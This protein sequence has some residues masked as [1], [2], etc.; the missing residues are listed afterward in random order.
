MN[1]GEWSPDEAELLRGLFLDEAKG[2]LRAIAV[3]QQT[4]ARAPQDPTEAISTLFRH[5]HTLKGS[6]GSVGYSTIARAAHELE[7]LCAEIRSFALAPTAG[8]LDRIDEGVAEL[9]AL[10]QG[11]HASPAPPPTTPAVADA[12]EGDQRRASDRRGAPDR[13]RSS[14]DGWLRIKSERLDSLVDRVGDLVILRTRIERRLQE[15]E[16]GLRDLR[17]TRTRLRSVLGKLGDALPAPAPTTTNP[18]VIL[19]QVAEVEL[20]LADMVAHLE[21]AS[22]ALGGEGDSLRRTS[23]QLDTE[24]RQ[25]RLVPLDTLFQRVAA[26]LRELEKTQVAADLVTNGGELEVDKSVAEHLAEPLLHLVRNALG[27]GIETP[28]VRAA[29]GKPVRGRIAITARHEG[30]FVFLKFEDDGRGIDP[31]AVKRTLTAAGRHEGTGLSEVLLRD[32]LFEPGFTT[33][34]QADALS[35]RGMG[36]DIVRRAVM[37]IGGEVSVELPQ[38]GESRGARFNLSVPLTAA[39]T[40]ALLFKVGGQVYATPTAH[41]V[42]ILPLRPDDLLVKG[43]GSDRPAVQP[44]GVA[45]PVPLLRLHALLGVETP[46]ARHAAALHMRHGARHLVVT[47]DKIIG[48]RTIVVRPLGAVLDSLPYYAGVTVSGAGK[49]Q[50]VLDVAALADVA[51]AAAAR[52]TSPPIRRAHPRILVV[53]DSRLGREAASRVLSGAGYQI[54]VAEDGFEAWELLGERRFDAVVTDL[55]MPRMD[56]FDLVARIRREPTLRH[57]PVVVLSSRTGRATRERAT[58]A[59]ADAVLPKAPQKRILADTVAA[60]LASQGVG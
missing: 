19:D 28:E 59:G 52:T 20:E 40:E 37:R 4:L 49:A 44:P 29:L 21:R 56:G 18:A 35:G 47:C 26:T 25:A 11:A 22:K 16:V 3:C 36:L 15:L 6:A 48:P 1:E 55:E 14:S 58:A 41:V 50:L 24:L 34:T 12:T 17:G 10:L 46:P 33:R 2:H 45:G 7:E 53:D 43:A 5:L 13:R 31:E 60:L 32:V 39:I 23:S 42:Q 38:A 9:R 8:I 30:D 51:H 27:H 57:L 54:I